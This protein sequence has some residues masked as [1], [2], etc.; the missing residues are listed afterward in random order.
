M[1]A[2]YHTLNALFDQLGLASSDQEIDEFITNNKPLPASVALYEAYFWSASQADF[3]EQGIDQDADWAV[4]I[5]RLDV[6]LR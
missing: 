5:D 2:S 1:E 3:L 4:I 6:I